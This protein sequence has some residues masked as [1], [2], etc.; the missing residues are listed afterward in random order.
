MGRLGLLKSAV[1]IGL[2]GS[3]V[4]ACSSSGGDNNNSGDS[5]Q[6]LQQMS[7]TQLYQKAKA[8]GTFTMYGDGNAMPTLF[9]SFQKAYPGIK[10]NLVDEQDSALAVRAQAEAA[11]GKVV[12]DVWASPTE[13]LDALVQGDL[14]EKFNPPEAAGFQPTD[15]TDYWV[16]NEVQPKTVCWNTSKVPA[17]DAPSTWSDLSDPKYK[18]YRI[19]IDPD[20]WIPMLAYAQHKFGGDM[21][22]AED[23]FKAIA[24]SNKLVPGTGGRAL[25]N[26]LASGEIDI[27]MSCVAHVYI[28]LKG[29]GAPL[30]IT[31]TESVPE[32]VGVAIL[33]GDPHPAAATLVARWLLSDAGQQALAA[34]GRIPA[35]SKFPASVDVTTQDDLSL[36][37]DVVSKNATKYAADWKKIFDLH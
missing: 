11:A 22:K 6:A 37:P 10:M 32:P 33:K 4:A 25:V 21:G 20:G 19:G 24:A 5:G 7:L 8:E 23:V 16:G 1:A 9:K 36:A 17:A 2:V 27:N 31:K 29:Q 12:G 15:R 14:I 30:G 28:Q 34:M 26:S 3:V 18:K 35:N 13:S